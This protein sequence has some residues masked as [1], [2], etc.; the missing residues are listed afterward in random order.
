MWLSWRALTYVH[1]ALASIP[2]RMEFPQSLTCGT[3]EVEAGRSGVQVLGQP[4]LQ[5]TPPQ[6]KTQ[7][8]PRLSHVTHGLL[9]KQ[10]TLT[11]VIDT[12]A[13]RAINVN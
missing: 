4:G 8:Q 11:Q 10:T 13:T 6:T 3:S 12:E 9:G 7:T 2:S 1:K 5:K